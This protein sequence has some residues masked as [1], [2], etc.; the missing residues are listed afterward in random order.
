MYGVLFEVVKNYKVFANSWY[1]LLA[2]SFSKISGVVLG[3][4]GGVLLLLSQLRGAEH[5]E[6][7]LR[8]LARGEAAGHGRATVHLPQGLV[9]QHQG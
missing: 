1:H 3:I 8:H 9:S 5:T 6:A 4:H 2:F 7:S